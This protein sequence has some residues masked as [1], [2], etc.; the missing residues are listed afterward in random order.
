MRT[1]IIQG[2]HTILDHAK[3]NEAKN[4][5][6][7]FSIDKQPLKGKNWYLKTSL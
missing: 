3:W 1:L 5:G 2:N 7:Q 4:L 6:N